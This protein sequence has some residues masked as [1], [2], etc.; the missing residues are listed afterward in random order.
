MRRSRFVEVTRCCCSYERE[1]LG[2]LTVSLGEVGWLG[3]I[4]GVGMGMFLQGC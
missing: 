1:R 2:S 3:L 4:G